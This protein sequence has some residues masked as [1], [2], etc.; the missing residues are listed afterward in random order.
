MNRAQIQ[1]LLLSG[2]RG[3]DVVALLQ[4]NTNNPCALKVILSKV[5]RDVLLSGDKRAAHPQLRANLAKMKKVSSKL[6]AKQKKKFAVFTE[7]NL[8][9]IYDARRKLRSEGAFF[10][11][12][13]LDS[14]LASLKI[15]PPNFDSFKLP[16]DIEKECKRIA[17]HNLKVKNENCKILLESRKA[18]ESVVSYL[19][20]AGNA[21]GQSESISEN[22]L[23]VCL[24]FVT[25]RRTS[26]ILNGE[27]TFKKGPT[28]MSLTFTGQLKKNLVGEEKEE[29]YEIPI[30]CTADI[31]LKAFSVLRE[32]QN[33][34]KRDN[35]AVNSKYASN[36]SF[37]CKKMFKVQPSSN[38]VAS[39]IRVHDLRALY[40][41]LAYQLFQYDLTG[42]SIN[43][44]AARVLGHTGIDSSLNYSSYIVK[45]IGEPFPLTSRLD[46]S[47]SGKRIRK[48]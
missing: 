38:S 29:S 41:V 33:N 21:S 13:K 5:K 30:L 34:V 45:N 36:L 7:S 10:G 1:E 35:A 42:F 11:D 28:D 6:N 19:T 27:S 18:L 22:K 26:E 24:L 32:K 23:A 48:R 37:W 3:T 15:L 46:L 2:E 8:K 25:G 16:P 17:A 44:F 31:F 9:Y 40:V 43:G 4:A 20:L 47:K 14:M 39:H 12:K